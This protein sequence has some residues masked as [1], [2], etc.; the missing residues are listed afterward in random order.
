MNDVNWGS[1]AAAIGPVGT[2][3]IAILYLISRT[4]VLKRDDPSRNDVLN[5]VRTT[6]AKLDKM[7]RELTDRLARIET[8]QSEH[9]RRLDKLE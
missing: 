2:L 9:G 7:D 1:L 3:A 6:N 4:D 5:E 8:R